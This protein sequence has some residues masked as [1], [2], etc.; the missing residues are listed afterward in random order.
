MP[1]MI[2]G[3]GY[4]RQPVLILGEFQHIRCA[5]EFDAVG[6]R[7]AQRF[8]E[9]GGD[10]NGNVMRLTIQDPRRLFRREPRGQLPEQR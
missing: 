8:Q 2:D 5:K 10:Q 4:F 7:I 3:I 9:A 1:V 6:G